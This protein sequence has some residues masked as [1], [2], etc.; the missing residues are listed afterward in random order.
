MIAA[1]FRQLAAALFR[2]LLWIRLQAADIHLGDLIDERCRL[3]GARG[4]SLALP[5]DPDLQLA[6]LE[7]RIA[8]A[9]AARNALAQRL[10]TAP[11]SSTTDTAWK[12]TP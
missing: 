10:A 12:T 4:R 3:E 7:R 2:P 8:A 5:A 9:Q 6:G 11:V 1:L